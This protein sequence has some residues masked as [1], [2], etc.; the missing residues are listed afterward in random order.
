MKF[1][2]LLEIHAPADM[3]A[4]N[5][6]ELA[7]QFQAKIDRENASDQFRV[8]GM[9]AAPTQTPDEID[10]WIGHAKISLGSISRRPPDAVK[11]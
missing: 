4:L 3:A 6:T 8:I 1:F 11:P 9:Y 10:R 5:E 2:V 7:R